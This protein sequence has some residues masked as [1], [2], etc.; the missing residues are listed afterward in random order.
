MLTVPR[1]S[2]RL[3]GAHI[4]QI[5]RTAGRPVSM[6]PVVAAAG[7]RARKIRPDWAMSRG[8]GLATIHELADQGSCP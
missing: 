1:L 7:S 8:L 3:G 6:R 5:G 4:A 2:P